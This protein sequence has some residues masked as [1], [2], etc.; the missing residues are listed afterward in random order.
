[1]AVRSGQPAWRDDGQQLS[2]PAPSLEIGGHEAIV[3]LRPRLVGGV[4]RALA[5]PGEVSRRTLRIGRERLVDLAAI[6]E[7]DREHPGG[8]H[9]DR[10]RGAH[11]REPGADREPALH[12]VL[13]RAIL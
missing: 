4:A 11:D 5:R 12:A 13:S 3:G 1:V 9:S 8:E 10:E 6:D 2:R 7:I